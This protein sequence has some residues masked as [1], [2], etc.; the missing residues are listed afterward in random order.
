MVSPYPNTVMIHTT[1]FT[2]DLR[3][4]HP[5]L[6]IE[7]TSRAHSRH[8]PDTPDIAEV[9]VFPFLTL[10]GGLSFILILIPL[11]LVLFFLVFVVVFLRMPSRRSL[12]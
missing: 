11:I 7:Y 2:T 12:A 9:M 6:G 4:I 10:L 3:R 5:D 1:V 8:L